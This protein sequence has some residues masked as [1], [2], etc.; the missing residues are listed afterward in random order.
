M[1]TPLLPPQGNAAKNLAHT[2]DA[3]SIT[4]DLDSK[5][6]RVHDGNTPGGFAL[7]KEG[8]THTLSEIVASLGYMP[9]DQ[10][11]IGQA[12]GV[13]GL[14]ATGKVPA[15]QLPAGMGG[16]VSDAADLTGDTLAEGVVNSSLTSV[17]TLV[18]LTVTNPIA[19]SV[20]GGAGKLNI[21]RQLSL[22]G[23]ATGSV[24]F[25]GSQ[26]GDIA[27]VLANVNPAPVANGLVK[28]TT[29]GKGLVTETS[30][31]SGDDLIDALGFSPVS[32]SYVDDVA[33]GMVARAA[34]RT[35]T[36]TALTATYNNGTGGNGATLTG[37]GSTPTIGGI[38]P[39]L[40][41]RVLV[42]DQLAGL[43]NGPY[44]LTAGNP[45]VLTRVDDV[46]TLTAGSAFYVQ[47]GTL[48]GTRWAQTT[49]NPDVGSTAVAY[50]QVEGG[51]TL[52]SGAGIAINNNE[53]S[54]TGVRSLAGTP[55][56]INVSSATGTPT[57]SLAP[58]ISLSGTITAS[59]F[60]GSGAFLTNLNASQLTSGMIPTARMGTG[61]ASSTT[62]L[63]GDG[64]WK[65]VTANVTFLN[66]T[67]AWP[68]A[69]TANAVQA[70][71]YGSG[72]VVSF[73]SSGAPTNQ[74]VTQL[75]N[76][77]SGSFYIR[78]LNDSNTS[79]TD[80]FKIARS[81]TS[82]TQITMTATALALQGNTSIAG[83]LNVSSIIT[84]NG[85]GLT[86]LNATN[87]SS[88][89]VPAARLGTGTAS[90]TTYLAGDGTWKSFSAG[91]ANILTG[92]GAIAR[93]SSVSGVYAGIDNASIPLVALI[94]NTAGAGLK[95]VQSGV[96]SDGSYWTAFAN[97]A[98][99]SQTKFFSVSRSNNVAT[100][101]TFTTASFVVSGALTVNGGSATAQSFIPSSATAPSNGLYLPAAGQVG[102]STGGTESIR[103]NTAGAIGLA[104]PNYGSAG[105]VLTSQGAGSAPVWSS[106]SAD[107]V[108]ATA[109]V[110]AVQTTTSGIYGGL[111][112]S[113][114]NPTFNFIN[115]GAS[116]NTRVM[117]Q[118]LQ[119][120]GIFDM[121]FM[122]DSGLSATSFM[123]VSRSTGSVNA[124]A[125]TF[126][127]TS[128]TVNAAAT[129]SNIS[130]SG[131][132]KATNG[133]YLAATNT[134]GIST[135][136]T[137][138]LLINA[139]GALGL[140]GANYGTAGQVLTSNGTGTPTW[141]TPAATSTS[142]SA[143]GSN[144]RSSATTGIYAGVVSGHPSVTF[145]NSGAATSNKLWTQWIDTAS[146]S[147]RFSLETDNSSS[148]VDVMTITRSAT[149]ASLL[150]FTSAAIN[151]AGLSAGLQLNGSVGTAG[152]VLTSNGSGAAPTWGSPTV[153]TVTATATIPTNTSA[154]G[155][156]GGTLSGNSLLQFVNLTAAAGQ[157]VWDVR[158]DTNGSFGIG[159]M[160]DAAASLQYGI[161]I[162]RSGQTLSNVVITGTAITLTGAVTGTSFAGNGASLT[163][164]NASNLST[165]TVPTARLG[166]GTAS[167]DTWLRG[168]GTWATLNLNGSLV[169]Q[170]PRTTT[171]DA[172]SRGKRVV[173]TADTTLPSGVFVEGDVI[174]LYNSG[175]T[176][177]QI[178]PPAGTTLWLDGTN[179]SGTRM[180]APH[181]TCSIWYNSATEA[182]ISGSVM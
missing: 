109:T 182:I 97:D 132:T 87:L 108:N 55:N 37:T 102:I 93:N 56:Q 63:S 79:S 48:Q 122:L 137:D 45:W 141:Q 149:A 6:L 11:S 36:T 154:S 44:E 174:T 74:K 181:G 128:F 151:L 136:G 134:V 143:T 21:A 107:A 27:V 73:V 145:V 59:G 176:D 35:A 32:K 7:S 169:T 106:V 60:S 130:V 168:D 126:S 53:I 133:L 26:D 49:V 42:K 13:A 104:G 166:S 2:G 156:Y 4:V 19:G 81:G 78:M 24:Q 148:S 95:V 159:L 30:A 153:S 39:S 83:S 1:F 179:Q 31:V 125:I 155:I 88:G 135:N 140:G 57:L 65:A 146:N 165:G 99:N 61:T 54:N 9:V 82:A 80:A 173:I 90:S 17:G 25:D 160:T 147:W 62:F 112:S 3:G 103:W 105:Q 33:A 41:D 150:T 127:A 144:P 129:V 84:G 139:N 115:S 123:T 158:V 18:N 164:L 34:V 12:N 71:S 67:G 161:R 68:F 28:I 175:T 38:T 110:A 142:L 172:N 113:G 167:S 20:T 77:T 163:A 117:Y 89:I 50:T 14:D 66:G 92:T 177:L 178:T 40:G 43:Q 47:E 157:R 124:N 58:S 180:L 100:S 120:T 76:D 86:A 94:N 51:A 119:N 72:G 118:R 114:S 85:S 22:S 15:A 52:T 162:D 116:V 29:N 23:D 46:S 16:G 69:S 171:L 91:S 111:T 75:I 121:G 131:S 5:T 8:H 70:G 138:S 64:T 101:V 10:A 98:I 170:I 96:D 152:Q